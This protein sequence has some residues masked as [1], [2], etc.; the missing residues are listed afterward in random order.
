MNSCQPT[1]QPVI[2][3]SVGRAMPYSGPD[4]TRK[5]LK[6]S[7]ELEWW[8]SGGQCRRLTDC[9]AR[10]QFIAPID[11]LLTTN[12]ALIIY[13]LTY[14]PSQSGAHQCIFIRAIVST[15][16][17][18]TIRSP[19]RCEPRVHT[20]TQEIIKNYGPS[21]PGNILVA[22]W[23]RG[24][25]NNNQCCHHAVSVANKHGAVGIKARIHSF[26]MDVCI[27]GHPLT[28]DSV[29]LD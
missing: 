22:I 20:H 23:H 21:V 4:C 14:G 15:W 13:L 27:H 2:H 29:G 8:I 12:L 1:N 25:C 5:N 19:L 7:S 28:T 3:P 24:Q 9:L 11:I 10:Y 16:A 17:L 26:M 6:Q 18:A